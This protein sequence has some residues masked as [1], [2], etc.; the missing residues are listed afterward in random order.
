MS[1]RRRPVRRVV[2][3]Q[4]IMQA[5]LEAL[6]DTYTEEGVQIWLDNPKAWLGIVPREAINC[7]PIGDARTVLDHALG[8]RGMQAT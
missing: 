1:A 5:V 3:R 6:R 2:E 4:M 7:G 8:L